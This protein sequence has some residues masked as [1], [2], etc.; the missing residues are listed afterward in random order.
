MTYQQKLYKNKKRSDNKDKEEQST[1]CG[2]KKERLSDNGFSGVFLTSLNLVNFTHRKRSSYR[3]L[4]H[5]I[6]DGSRSKIV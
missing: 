3:I 5:L 4:R 6:T 2:H 1:D